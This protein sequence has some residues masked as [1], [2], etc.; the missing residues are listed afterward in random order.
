MHCGPWHLIFP[1]VA[2]RKSWF[3]EIIF[4]RFQ[5]F[6]VGSL[7]FSPVEGLRGG[8]GGRGTP[9]FKWQ[10][11]SNRGENQ[12]PKKIPA[13]QN[14]APKKSHAE[15]PSLKNFQIALNDITRKTETLVLN[16]PKKS[17]LKSSYPK[18]NT[19]PKFSYPQKIPKLKNNISTP[20]LPPQNP[21]IIP[22]TWNLE[23]P[24]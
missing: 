20:P 19:W 8:G 24:P 1:F 22:V 7:Q 2:T 6:R 12:K 3:Y 13:D 16:T 14:L 11:W 23:Y 18:K 5:W 15:F 17:L 9:D 21:S 10:G 4:F